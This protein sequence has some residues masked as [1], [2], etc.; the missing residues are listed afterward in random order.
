[1]VAIIHTGP[2]KA[3]RIMDGLRFLVFIFMKHNSYV[4]VRHVPG[5]YNEIADALSLFQDPCFRA[6]ASPPLP[7]PSL[8][9]LLGRTFST[10]QT[11]DWLSLQITPIP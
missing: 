5:V 10:T 1:V 8:T 7:R 6:V 11:G 3:P 9:T 2:S 4:T